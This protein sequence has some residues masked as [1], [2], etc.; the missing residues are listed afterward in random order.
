MPHVLVLV[1]AVQAIPIRLQTQPAPTQDDS[2]AKLAQSETPLVHMN[3]REHPGQDEGE[4][5]AEGHEAH[6]A[7]VGVPLQLGVSVGVHPGQSLHDEACAHRSQLEKS[8]VVGPQ[9]PA[10]PAVQPGQAPHPF[11]SGHSEQAA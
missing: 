3:V 8:D 9:T 1:P 6:V 11:D 4:Q 7:Y 10:S 2:L 5:S